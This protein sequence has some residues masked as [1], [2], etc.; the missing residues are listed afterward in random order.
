M[1]RECKMCG[2]FQRVPA[3]APGSRAACPRCDTTLCAHRTD[4]EGRA[5]AL[6]STG[7]LLFALAAS[8]PFLALDLAGGRQTDLTTGPWALGENG[9]WEVGLV[10]LATTILAPMARLAALIFVLLGLRAD[11]PRAWL[12]P[13]LRWVEGLAPWSMIEVFL[14]GVFVAYTKLSDMAPVHP[15]IAVYAL[16]G[17]MLATAAMDR[18]VDHEA[19]WA[20]LETA[21][22]AARCASG[23]GAR[24][25]C[26]DC[27]Q[28]STS[29]AARPCPRCQAPLTHR[30]T[31]SLERSWA[32]L[33]A[34]AVFYIPANTLPVLT[35]IQLGR[36][37]PSTIL[38]GVSELAAGG[39]WPLAVL[40]FVASVAVP[41]LKLLSLAAL[42]MSVRLR[43]R[44]GLRDR[45]RLYRMVE[46]VGRWSMIDVFMVSI[47]TALVQAGQIATVVPGAGVLCFCAVVILTMLAANSFDPR[48][49]WDAAQPETEPRPP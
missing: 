16:G 2:L 24:I 27:G 40:V 38:G 8:Q 47:L 42:L 41:V 14:L 7:V 15:G 19:L 13:P 48:L 22:L 32:L 36:G 35:A 3:L 44:A 30:K 39:Q 34:A 29:F 46:A 6:A 33:I 12:V 1:V 18:A 37:E 23:G 21:D 9:L 26:D 25:G 31:A 17:L 10:V 11:L 5:L 43:H 20:R 4:P 45:T 28:V 49:M